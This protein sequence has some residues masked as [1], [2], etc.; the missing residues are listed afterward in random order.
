M[1]DALPGDDLLQRRVVVNDVE[2]AE[3][4]LADMRGLELV[5]RPAL[6]AFQPQELGHLVSLEWE[7]REATDG[8][9]RSQGSVRGYRRRGGLRRSAAALR[10]GDSG[11]R[12]P[13]GLHRLRLP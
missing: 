8:Q 2:R 3:A 5:L 6:A 11:W 10:A 9:A 7:L 13:A 12:R 4:H 1:F